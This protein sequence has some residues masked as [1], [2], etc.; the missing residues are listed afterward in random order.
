[1]KLFKTTIDEI[2]LVFDCVIKK[3]KGI[4]YILS[5]ESDMLLQIKLK[6]FY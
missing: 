1:M 2:L 5:I 4:S 6:K 3:Y